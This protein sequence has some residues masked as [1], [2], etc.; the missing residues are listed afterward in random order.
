MHNGK[1]IVTDNFC[2][3]DCYLIYI[4]EKRPDPNKYKPYRGKDP[5]RKII[6]DIFQRYYGCKKDPLL[7]RGVKPGT[8]RG[9]YNKPR[10]E[11]NEKIL[12]EQQRKQLLRERVRRYR[13][14]KKE[15]ELKRKEAQI[16]GM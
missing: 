6:D 9:E 8:K 3:V 15:F 16:H 7:K 1:A 12:K 4:G 14:K 10:L 5:E 2:S 13:Q 11:R